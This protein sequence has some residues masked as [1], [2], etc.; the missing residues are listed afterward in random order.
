MGKQ[1]VATDDLPGG[2][3]P[4]AAAWRREALL[5]ADLFSKVE[6]GR[7]LRFPRHALLVRRD[8]GHARWWTRPLAWLLFRREARALGLVR[9][10][11]G[12]PP[13]V[14]TEDTALL[15]GWIEGR[16]LQ[17]ARPCDAAFY[18]D[19]LRLLAQIHRRG[20]AH[21]DL[22]KKP[23]WLMRPDGRAA[24]VDFQLATAH[25]RRGRLFRLLAREDLRHLMKHKRQFAPEHLTRRQAALAASPSLPSR[26]WMAT[27]K[28]AY[29]L[30]TRR[31]LGW[32]DREGANDRTRMT[33]PLAEA[34]LLRHPAVAEA[35]VVGV[36]DALAGQ[37]LYAFV[38]PRARAAACPDIA[39]WVEAEA[40]AAARPDYVQW[41][42]A[43][44]RGRDGAV[45]RRVLRKIAEGEA[46]RIGGD[47]AGLVN[48]EVLP[49]LIAGRA[50][51]R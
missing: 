7:D 9:G 14:A 28:R 29:Y 46:D 5:K 36:P 49:A 42:E 25:R 39:G 44:P 32:R 16:P 27:G 20:V 15:R 50:A 51:R 1:A 35:A 4:D 6:L 8:L 10:I 48:P 24:V 40:G 26:L 22:A 21:N 17:V 37:G 2:A 31:I 41:V 3:A 33:M 19:A 23:N 13:L 34:A 38:V 30:V 45:H 18:R 47:A 43:L 12:V 11:E